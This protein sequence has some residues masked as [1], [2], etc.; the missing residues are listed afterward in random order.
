M[1]ERHTTG[2]ASNWLK[3]RAYLSKEKWISSGIEKYV[4]QKEH[5]PE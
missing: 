5:W 4:T 2:N 1:D 3:L